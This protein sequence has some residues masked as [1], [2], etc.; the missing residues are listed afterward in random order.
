LKCGGLERLGGGSLDRLL[1]FRDRLLA[2]PGFRRWAA[3]FPLTRPFARRR[4]RALF[5]LCAGFVYS[6]VLLACVRLD[7]LARLHAS[8]PDSAA[9]L[10]LRIGLDE[11]A[12]RRL[13]DAAAS[14]GLVRRRAGARYGLGPLGAA[15]ATEPGVAAMVE[16]HAML[17]RDLQDPVALLRAGGGGGALARYWAYAGR[18]DPS[19][20]AAH[21]VA[22][23]SDL[24]AASQAFIA[25]EVLDAYAPRRHR[26]LLDVGGG[27]GS[28]LA[29]AAA[30]APHLELMLFDL[31][32]VAERA[33]ERLRERGLAA[34]APHLELML[35]DLPAVAER[36]RE[37]LRE[38]GLAA[39]ARTFG[40]DFRRDPLPRG[41]DLVSLVRVVHDHDDE[42]AMALLRAARAA[43]EP[44]GALLLAEPMAGTRGALPSGDAYFGFYLLAM[45][46]GRPRRSGE[47]R[48]MLRAAGFSTV[49]SVPTYTPMLVRVLLAR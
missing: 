6:Q 32:A 43:L 47:L 33:R 44:G 45:G 5:D 26:C 40:G 2:S 16:H 28:F 15:L 11:P 46:S 23:Y 38:R 25:G 42:Q 8:G 24:M 17:Y 19:A 49:K 31:P 14:L 36:A 12:T 10:A 22:P 9:G 48:S 39:R 18:G 1:D 29:A 27:D 41:A 30:R 7:L 21:E 4:A 20:T 37:R 35:F 3:A 13:L 34:R